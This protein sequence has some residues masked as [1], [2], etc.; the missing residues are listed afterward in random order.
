MVI[1][2]LGQ[3]ECT[4]TGQKCDMYSHQLFD[5]TLNLN[6][7]NDYCASTY[8]GTCKINNGYGE[9]QCKDNWTVQKCDMYSQQLFDRTLH[10]D[11]C[12][13]YCISKYQGTCMINNGYGECQCNRV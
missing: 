4:W 12:N 1:L 8:K 13:D 6:T 3:G 9:C 10:L 2:S 7:C 5:R 11:T